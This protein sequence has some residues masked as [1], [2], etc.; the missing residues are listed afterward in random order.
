MT[1]DETRRIALIRYLSSDGTER[2][3]SG[4][5]VNDHA[6]L[7]AD[8][9]AEGTGH[10]V[11]CL[12]G[13]HEVAC[14]L[15]TRSP[16]IDLAV[17]SLKAP[18][19]GLAP[20]RCARVDQSRAGQIDSCMAL[21]FPRW[22]RDGVRRRAAQVNGIIPTGE[23]LEATAGDGLRLGFL[24]LVGNRKP[25]EPIPPGVL[26]DVEMPS[27]WGGMSGAVVVAG[28]LVIGVVRSYN[29]AAD[30]QSLTVTPV[31]AI[32]DLPDDAK[33]Q[34]FWAALGVSD[35]SGLP[36]LPAESLGGSPPRHRDYQ[37]DVYIS[38]WPETII[39]PWIDKRFLSPFR[40]ML[41][42]ELGRQPSIFVAR[43]AHAAD[44]AILTSRTL[45]A[46]LSKRFFFD[47]RCRAA[48]E[49]MLHRQIAEGFSTPHN[50]IRLVH[51]IIAHD[52]RSEEHVPAEYRGQFR[53]VNFRDWAYDFEIQDWQTHKSFND[54]IGELSSTI[55]DA[56]TQAPAWRPGFP[57]CAPAAL[58]VPTSRRPTF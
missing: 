6:I 19:S 26:G 24:T 51:A 20:L 3:G 8:H 41:F 11:D 13:T 47:V 17:L 56:V 16:D 34:E 57:L 25:V 38:Y 44:E 35:P 39:E 22:K 42:E 54:A 37:Y 4:L 21:G 53:P 18:V 14:V 52:F 28:S 7:T 48:F 27:A 9:I 33:R 5:L 15:R 49:S 1:A 2:V 50:P 30:G 10:R 36:L 32:D 40:S 31:T 46:I 45:L 58:I 29:L 43:D 12:D 23:G 55:A